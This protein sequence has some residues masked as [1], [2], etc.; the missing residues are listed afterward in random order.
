MKKLLYTITAFVLCGGIVQANA[1]CIATPSCTAM[2]Y[3]S[4]SSCTN[5]IKCPFGEYWNCANSDLSNK[6]TELETEIESLKQDSAASSCKIGSILFSDKTC[7]DTATY[8]KT[9]IGVVVYLGSNGG[10]AL[11]LE[12]I[13]KFKWSSEVKDISTL[14]NISSPQSDF[15]S[16]E[17]T[18]NIIALGDKNKYPAAWAAHEYSTVGTSVGDWCLPASGIFTTYYN[19]KDIINAG[20][21]AANGDISEYTDN[22]AWTS[23]EMYNGDYGACT[24]YAACFL[25]YCNNGTDAYVSKTSSFEVRPVIEFQAQKNRRG[26]SVFCFLRTGAECGPCHRVYSPG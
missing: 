7:G 10:Q 23:T 6:I 26:A 9:P 22:Y 21:L 12:S 17:N 4:S 14:P 25:S 2:G 11:A 1:A 15:S 8:G 24:A 5:G 16:C 19:Y 13:G 20:L 3:T 18:N